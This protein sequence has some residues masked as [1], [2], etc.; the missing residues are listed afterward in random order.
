M[1]ERKLTRKEAFALITSI[2]DD[3]AD[4]DTRFA[5]FEY[6]EKDRE[7]KEEFESVKRIKT[8]ISTRC[9]YHKAP[10]TLKVRVQKF[11]AD[12]KKKPDLDTL[13]ESDEL[14]LDL[15]SHIADSSRSNTGGN[16]SS[17]PANQNSWAKWGYAAAASLIIILAFWGLIFINQPASQTYS[18]E[19]HVF[20]HFDSHNGRMVDPTIATASLA[21]A[22]IQLSNTYDMHMTIPPMD[23][24]EFKGVI[25][26]EFVPNFSAPMFEYYLPGEDQYI[27]IFAFNLENLNKFEKLTRDREAVQNCLNKDDFHIKNVNG[28]HVLSWRWNGTWYAAISNHDGQTLAS[29]VKPLNYKPREQE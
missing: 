28:K 29:M 20:R 19:E 4:E 1:Y 16:V 8:L 6:I 14:V 15:P 22:E 25:Y 17:P 23:K 5:F 9:P 13:A 11:L 7:V 26:Q 10:E 27:Y 18:I 2:I 12:G 3:E 21:D 24:A